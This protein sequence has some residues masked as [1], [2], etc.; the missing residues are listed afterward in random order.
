MPYEEAM[1]I[2]T[3]F[4]AFVEDDFDTVT[5]VFNKLV[6]NYEKRSTRNE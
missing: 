6:D 4:N 2:Y 3:A 5:R 1:E